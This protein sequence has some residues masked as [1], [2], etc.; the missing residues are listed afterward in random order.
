MRIIVFEYCNKEVCSEKLW[1]GS[2]EPTY[3]IVEKYGKKKIKKMSPNEFSEFLGRLREDSNIIKMD[4]ISYNVAGTNF[5][6][7][8][9]PPKEN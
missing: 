4:A 5:V 9:Y 7:G 6:I 1:I 8:I 2:D 3:K